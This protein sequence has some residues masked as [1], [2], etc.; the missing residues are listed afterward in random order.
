LSTELAPIGF[1]K[2]LWANSTLSG[3]DLHEVSFLLEETSLADLGLCEYA[4]DR[5]FA[6]MLEPVGN[7][8]AVQGCP[9][10]DE[11]GPPRCIVP[12]LREKN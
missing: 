4:D 8:L 11:K 9:K 3:A 12:T 6:D 5:V 7:R 1:S 10:R 2:R